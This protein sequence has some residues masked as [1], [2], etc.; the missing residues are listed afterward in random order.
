MTQQTT[1]T[2]QA[3][4]DGKA[5]TRATLAKMGKLVKQYKTVPVIRE[6]ALQIIRRVPGKSWPGEAAAIQEWVRNNV[7]YVRDVAGVETLQS[8]VQTLR[9]KQ[10]DC[11]DQSTLAASLLAAIGHPTRFIAIG[12]SKG[13]FAHVL[14]QT[15]VGSKWLPLETTEGWAFGEIPKDVAQSIV[16]QMTHHN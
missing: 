6:L 15:K 12:F 9:L 4:P 5:G 3:I 7:R 16:E 10:G 14:T 13:H 1:Y 2:L 11:D 8:P